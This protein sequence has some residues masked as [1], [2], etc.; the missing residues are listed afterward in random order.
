[1]TGVGYRLYRDIRDFAPQDWTSGE[2]VVAWVIADDASD[3]SRHSLIPGPELC[4]RAHMSAEGV[5]KALAK[6]AAR[7]YEFRVS[8][9]TGKDGREVYAARNHPPE[10]VVPDVFQILVQAAVM[11]AEP[12]DNFTEGGTTVPP[13]AGLST[14]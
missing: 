1:M 8:H 12:V 6:L 4:R 5:R 14:G 10:Y 9:G 7:G 13:S 11:A 3:A 2:L